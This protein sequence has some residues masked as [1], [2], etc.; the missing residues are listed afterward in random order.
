MYQARVVILTLIALMAVLILASCKQNEF[1]EA[2]VDQVTL[3]GRQF[4]RNFTYSNQGD[5]PY[6][7]DIAKYLADNGAKIES[8]EK[9]DILIENSEVWFNGVNNVVKVKVKFKGSVIMA[10]DVKQS[11]Q[12]LSITDREKL[13]VQ[14]R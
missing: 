6:A 2:P 14:I 12:G 1:I 5:C 7:S 8:K 9:A 4:L 10:S 13:N 3:P 11:Q